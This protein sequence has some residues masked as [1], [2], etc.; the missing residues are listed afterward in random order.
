MAEWQPCL[1]CFPGECGLGCRGSFLV[2]RCKLCS[3]PSTASA[4]CLC[5]NHAKPSQANLS[6]C[7]CLYP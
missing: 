6:S 4:N 2:S 7:P 1:A 3:A 5:F